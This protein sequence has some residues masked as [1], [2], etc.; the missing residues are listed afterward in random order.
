MEELLKLLKENPNG[1][2]ATVDNGKPRVRPFGFI[3]EEEGRF[4]FCTNS[5]K[6]VY[7][8][9]IKVPYIEY[10]VTTKDMV[11]VRISGEIEFSDDIATKEKVLNIYEPVKLGYKSADNPIFKVFYMEHE[12]ATISD[13]SRKQPKKIEF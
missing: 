9:L 7:K 8:Q 10:A 12:T 5:L 11:T 3:L 1:V 2:L 6:E 4:Y 13:F